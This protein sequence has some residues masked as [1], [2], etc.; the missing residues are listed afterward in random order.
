MKNLSVNG[1]RRSVKQFT[2]PLFIFTYLWLFFS[3]F[4]QNELS[5]MRMITRRILSY[6]SLR[7]NKLSS[8]KF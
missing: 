6:K 2:K 8:P 3:V 7:K 4:S 1:A 5:G